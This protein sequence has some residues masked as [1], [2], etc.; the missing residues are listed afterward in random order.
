MSIPVG[1]DQD[2]TLG[3][4][5][6][7]SIEAPEV[8][9]ERAALAENMNKAIDAVLT[10]REQFVIRKRYG[11]YRSGRAMTLEDVGALLNISRERIRQIESKAIRKMRR[12]PK[13]IWFVRGIDGG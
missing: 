7:S 10:E 4:F 13:S 1:E 12:I 2:S 5:I 11:L 3:D 6:P 9:A 8:R